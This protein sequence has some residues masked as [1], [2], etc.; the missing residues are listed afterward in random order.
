MAEI[1]LD[2]QLRKQKTI[3]YTALQVAGII[4]ILLIGNCF[5]WLNMKFD[6]SNFTSWNYWNGVIQQVL[7]YTIA[8]VIGYLGRLQ[9][10]FLSNKEFA[11]NMNLYHS[12][13]AQ[14]TKTFIK[15]VERLINPKIQKEYYYAHVTKKLYKLERKNKKR[16]DFKI[17]YEKCLEWCSLNHKSVKDYTISDNIDGKFKKIKIKKC[18]R[19]IKN[20]WN[21]EQLIDEKLI[22]KNAKTYS[23]YPRVNAHAFTWGVRSKDNNSNQYKVEN[24]TIKDLSKRVVVKM[25]SVVLTSM[26]LGSIAADASMNEL[27]GQAYGWVKLLIKYAIRVVTIFWSYGSGLFLGKG[28]FESNYLSVVDNRNRILGE[29]IDW[30]QENEELEE[31]RSQKIR[32][33]ILEKAIQEE[34]IQSQKVPEEQEDDDYDDDEYEEIELTKEQVEERKAHGE[35]IVEK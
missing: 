3:L 33:E 14:K 9:K 6:F 24:T 29:Y 18:K 31:T 1:Q 32:R 20:R 7:M 16:D 15:F 21:L 2:P 19:Y 17:E 10:E 23:N 28:I 34:T 30:K 13:L 27:A 5:D 12:Y 4:A 26:L 22:D 35:I 8:M 25:L 11:I